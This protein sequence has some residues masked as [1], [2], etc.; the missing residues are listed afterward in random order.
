MQV[1]TGTYTGNGTSQ[2][3][4]GMGFAGTNAA[5]FVKDTS[6]GIMMLSMKGMT[7]G[8]SITCSGTSATSTTAITSRDADGFSVGADGNA[9]TN[10][11]TYYYLAILD[12]AAGDCEIGTFTGN[13]SSRTINMSQSFTPAALFVIGVGNDAQ[14]DH[15]YFTTAASI[16]AGGSLRCAGTNTI[17]SGQVT[18][19]GVGTFAVGTDGGTNGNTGTYGYIAFKSSPNIIEASTYTGNGTDNHDVTFSSAFASAPDWIFV[20]TDSQEGVHKPTALAGDASLYFSGTA[21]STDRIQSSGSGPT[22]QVG[23]NAQV[24]T[25]ATTYYYLAIRQL[26]N[27]TLTAAQGSFS[28]TGNAAN[29]LLTILASVGSFTVTMFNVFVQIT[30]HWSN[31][32]K[33]NSSWTNTPKN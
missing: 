2:A 1:K 8:Q 16:S 6:T 22:F 14:G 26:Q 10:A 32:I 12:N 7:A 15:L 5:I 25:N 9:N 17:Q 30:R 28:L 19:L 27:L 11:R 4:T 18:A 23:T 24:N 13:G 33:S 21:V 20:K 29:F 31:G 3:I